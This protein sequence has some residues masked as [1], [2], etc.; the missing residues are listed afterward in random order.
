MANHVPLLSELAEFALPS[1]LHRTGVTRNGN[2]AFVP[3]AKMKLSVHVIV[4]IRCGRCDMIEG[5][6]GQTD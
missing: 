6:G 3:L 5:V 1:F 4:S 2:D